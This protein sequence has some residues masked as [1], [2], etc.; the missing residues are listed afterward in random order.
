MH[1][2]N[3]TF[4]PKGGEPYVPQV[5]ITCIYASYGTVESI[6]LTSHQRIQAHGHVCNIQSLLSAINKYHHKGSFS[7]AMKNFYQS[8]LMDMLHQL[9]HGCLHVRFCMSDKNAQFQLFRKC[10]FEESPVS[11]QIEL[12]NAICNYT[13]QCIYIGR[14]GG[15]DIHTWS[16]SDSNRQL[17]TRVTQFRQDSDVHH[18]RKR[19]NNDANI[20]NKKHH[21]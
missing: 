12:A 17:F 13:R 14:P 19:T 8:A 11:V 5:R 4:K 15:S 21:A 16:N 3:N 18:K 2:W 6:F 20:S 9:I 7:I 1:L 10:D